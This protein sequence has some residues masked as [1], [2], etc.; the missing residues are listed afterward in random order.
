MG[1]EPFYGWIREDFE[2]A[3]NEFLPFIED[4]S[5]NG[6]RWG[7]GASLGGTIKFKS[8]T[9]EPFING[10]YQEIKLDGDGTEFIRSLILDINELQRQWYIGGGFS[11]LFGL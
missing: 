2:N 4:V 6:S 7:M 1:L 10:G 5:L 3:S 8:L 11:V 9:L